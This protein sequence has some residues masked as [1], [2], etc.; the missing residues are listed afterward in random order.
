MK[1]SLAVLLS[2]CLLF[3]Q[4]S[5]IQAKENEDTAAKVLNAVNILRGDGTSYN[6][7][8]SLNRAE[9]ATFIVRILG[10]E[11]EV[12]ADRGH[13]VMTG[14]S[15]VA[16]VDWY[17]P[18]IGYCVEHGI[19]NGFTDGTFKPMESLSEKA[20]IKILL[21]ALGYDYEADFEWTSVFQT[22]YNAKLVTEEH[23]ATGIGQSSDFTRGDVVGLLY[24]T[25]KMNH[26]VTGIRMATNLLESSDTTE[27]DLID[28]GLLVRAGSNQVNEFRRVD[29][30]YF[31]LELSSIPSAVKEDNIKI[32]DDLGNELKVVEISSTDLQDI[33]S[34]RTEGED[35]DRSY[36]VKIEGIMDEYGNEF[37]EFETEFIGFRPDVYKSDVFA[38]S[39][40]KQLSD[41]KISITFTHPINKKLL[42]PEFFYIIHGDNIIADGEQSGDMEVA[43]SGSNTV[44][45]TLQK[46]VFNDDEE[47]TLVARNT[48]KS[49]YRVFLNQNED[50]SIRFIASKSEIEPFE[51]SDFRLIEEDKLM[52]EVNRTINKTVGEQ[53][54]SYY[55]IDDKDNPIAISKVTVNNL[56]DKA[57][58]T[59]TLDKNLEEDEDYTLMINQMY[60]IDREESMIEQSYEFEAELDKEDPVDI[61]DVEQ[62]DMSTVEVI[63]EQPM[64]VDDVTNPDF[65]KFELYHGNKT[66]SPKAIYYN[67]DT[68]SATVYFGDEVVMERNADYRLLISRGMRSATGQELENPYSERFDAKTKDPIEVGIDKSVYLGD[69]IIMI[70]T[71]LPV[72]FSETTINP[73]NYSLTAY[74]TDEK[75]EDQVDGAFAEVDAVI[76]YDP[77][78]ILLLV[79]DFDN[80]KYYELVVETLMNY[81]NFNYVKDVDVE[82]DIARK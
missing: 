37:D 11:E 55:V 12:M 45:V 53:L 62:V 73:N 67:N 21:V 29:K 16:A 15:D 27:E 19:I 74:D 1:R 66:Y 23:Y 32:T 30:D 20:M 51:A 68:W 17:A 50:D 26:H 61:D 57:N 43:I 71:D 6:L 40:V 10:K 35:K 82:I 33:Y 25:L 69:N 59:L 38:I 28:Q 78:H 42:G 22:A 47:Y 54:F 77:T 18:Y 44:I 3:G 5:V 65:Y 49:D 58:V 34:V 39:E 80:E 9:G 7:D 8:Q 14:F 52:F 24:R 13:Y 64:N 70:E 46:S 81:G 36:S 76:Y 63:F 48:L 60:T 79:S 75:R 31:S 41:R 72:G 2:L 56:N 4:W